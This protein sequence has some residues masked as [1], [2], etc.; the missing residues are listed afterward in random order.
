M[1]RQHTERRGHLLEVLPD[2]LGADQPHVDE[3]DFDGGQ[4]DAG[5]DVLELRRDSFAD[6][7]R[8][9]DVRRGVVCQRAEDGHSPPLGALVQG[10]EQLLEGG[11]RDDQGLGL[12]GRLGDLGQG[13]DLSLIHI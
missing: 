8:L 11:W 1:A 9:L 12:R 6:M 4:D 3:D 2:E 13:L 10:H 7:L 5:V